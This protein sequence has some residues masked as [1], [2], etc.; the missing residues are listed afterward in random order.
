MI[1]VNI[2]S[3]AGP[4]NQLTSWEQETIFFKL[5][6][7]TKIVLWSV[8]FSNVFHYHPCNRAKILHVYKQTLRVGPFFILHFRPKLEE[9][10]IKFVNILIF[11]FTMMEEHKSWIFE[12]EVPRKIFR[13]WNNEVENWG[14]YTS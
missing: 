14:C 9:L 12:N 5:W 10:H 13:P 11:S 2:Y 4:Q 6:I 7:M 3:M 8:T 1:I